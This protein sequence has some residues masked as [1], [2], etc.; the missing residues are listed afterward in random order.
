M[1]NSNS[2]Q[3]PVDTSARGRASGCVKWFN[4]KS[5]YGF[6]TVTSQG[7]YCGEDVFVHHSALSV[8]NEDQY[9]Y[10]V[11]GEYVEFD[12][13]HTDSSDHEWQAG[14]VKGVNGGKLMCETRHEM[15]NERM[16]HQS[17][18]DSHGDSYSQSHPHSHSQSDSGNS[19]RGNQ[20][21]RQR[22]AGPREGEEWL[23]VR[24]KGD[25]AGRGGGNNRGNQRGYYKGT[26]SNWKGGN[27]DRN[28]DSGGDE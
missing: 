6:V 14:N 20:N 27:P 3:T 15:R 7:D 23:L 19:Q 12:W 8:S 10:L 2:E 9:R 11:Q 1:S 5:G 24:R 21:Y 17:N 18:S 22:G 26:N 4:N 28:K 25:G 13:K 16:S